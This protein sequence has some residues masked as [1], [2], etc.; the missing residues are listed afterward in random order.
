M[1]VAIFSIRLLLVALS[2]PRVLSPSLWTGLHEEAVTTLVAVR[3]VD[4]N[5]ANGIDPG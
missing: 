5:A 1:I 3:A 2:I 4:S